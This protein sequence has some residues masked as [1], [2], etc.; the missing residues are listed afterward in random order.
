[1]YLVE[2]ENLDLGFNKINILNNIKVL[3][4][5]VEMRMFKY[6]GFIEVNLEGN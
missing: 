2:I 6:N 3:K 1:M 4:Q 5:L